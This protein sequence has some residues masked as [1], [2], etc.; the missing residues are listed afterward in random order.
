MQRDVP[1]MEIARSVAVFFSYAPEQVWY[2]SGAA[3]VLERAD[4]QINID[5]ACRF[6]T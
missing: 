2:H 4:S 6:S 3:S 1:L 5:T